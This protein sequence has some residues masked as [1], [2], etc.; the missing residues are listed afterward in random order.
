ME[1]PTGPNPNQFLSIDWATTSSGRDDKSMLAGKPVSVLPVTQKKLAVLDL[2]GIHD[3]NPLHRKSSL[4]REPRHES[5]EELRRQVEIT[6]PDY[7]TDSEYLELSHFLCEYITEDDVRA[8]PPQILRRFAKQAIKDV[9][10]MQALVKKAINEQDKIPE[11]IRRTIIGKLF[12]LQKAYDTLLQDFKACKRTFACGE[13]IYEERSVLNPIDSSER[14]VLLTNPR[15]MVQELKN[16]WKQLIRYMDQL[17]A[18]MPAPSE[19]CPAQMVPNI[20]PAE[21]H[22]RIPLAKRRMMDYARPK[23]EALKSCIEKMEDNWKVLETMIRNKRIPPYVEAEAVN[24]HV[25]LPNQAKPLPPCYDVSHL[26]VDTT[27]RFAEEKADSGITT[28]PRLISKESKPS[29]LDSRKEYF[30]DRASAEAQKK[31]L[32][33]E[34]KRKLKE[35]K[36]RKGELSLSV[37]SMKPVSR[38]NPK[39]AEY[40]QYQP[41]SLDTLEQVLHNGNLLIRQAKLPLNDLI[42]STVGKDE[43]TEDQYELFLQHSATLQK[44]IEMWY[45]HFP[46]IQEVYD[47]IY[48]EDNFLKK[49]VRAILSGT[50]KQK[51]KHLERRNS[52]TLSTKSRLQ[53]GRHGSLPDLSPSAGRPVFRM[54][55]FPP[56]PSPTSP[57]S[58]CLTSSS[59]RLSP[60]E[61]ESDGV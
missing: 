3:A 43:L 2:T 9:K 10:Y 11:G 8:I 48:E 33:D 54:E 21:F 23:L 45:K 6:P 41:V 34:D 61:K 40:F 46:S 35:A 58:S 15:D 36:K 42:A 56:T 22:E 37:P 27:S 31:R 49:G 28:N 5:I 57:G 32:D 30:Q 51:Q 53:I 25:C 44:S 20:K 16:R 26:A 39:P 1:P 24:F 55:T 14:Y 59:R 60:E 17:R 52:M 12:G 18:T 29:D 19:C 7:L 38:F 4:R 47:Y 13:T 50:K